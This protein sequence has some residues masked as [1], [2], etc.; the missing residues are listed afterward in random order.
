MAALR[1][2]L[3]LPGPA[4]LSALILIAALLWLPPGLRTLLFVLA[5]GVAGATA[6]PFAVVGLGRRL[7]DLLLDRWHLDRRHI[8]R[9]GGPK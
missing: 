4:A 7:L 6:L 9:R 3:P 2:G 8:D 5:G 1:S